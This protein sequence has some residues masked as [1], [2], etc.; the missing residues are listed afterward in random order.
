VP[1]IEGDGDDSLVPISGT[2]RVEL[3]R[4]GYRS[5]NEEDLPRLLDLLTD[6][7]EVADPLHDTFVRGR[8]AITQ[9]WERTQSTAHSV[10]LGAVMEIGDSVIAVVHHDFYDRETGLLGPGL[11]EVHRFTFRGD[12]VV[13]LEVSTFG[14]LSREV[15]DRLS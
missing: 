8:E 10:L 9:L 13:K 1:R 6:D 3:I 14:E 2:S 4:E 5:F 11:E 15:R 7:A 12:R